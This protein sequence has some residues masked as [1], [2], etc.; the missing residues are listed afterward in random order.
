MNL[1]KCISRT[2]ICLDSL[3][4]LLY[5]LGTSNLIN[6]GMIPFVIDQGELPFHNLDYLF[7]PKIREA[8][9]DGKTEFEAYVVKDGALKPFT[10]RMGELT[11][12]EKDIIL[13]GCLINYYRG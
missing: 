5:F 3:L 8:I 7:V 13:K 12:D 1:R 10:L 4:C 2:G 9:A 6:W 11:P